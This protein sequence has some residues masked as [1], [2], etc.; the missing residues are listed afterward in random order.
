MKNKFKID[1]DVLIIYNRSDNREIIC[2]A[3]DYDLVSQHTWCLSYGYAVT[4]IRGADG[5]YKTM[6]LHRLLMNPPADVQVDHINGIKHDN[7][8]S[9]LRIVTSQENNHNRRSANGY[10]WN[11]NAGKYRADI[12]INKKRINLGYYNTEDEARQ[13]YLDA[14][15]LYHPSAPV[16][17]F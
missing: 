12:A 14:K 15:R 16:M 11:K 1:S 17:S 9:N 2:D 7:R 10:Y 3:T 8:R 13:A 4:N 6:L 5:K